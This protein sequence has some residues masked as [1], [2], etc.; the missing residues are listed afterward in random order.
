MIVY[1]VARANYI[2]DLSGAG[3]RR[4][5]GRWNEKGSA[6]LYAAQ[7]SSLAILEALAHSNS[8]LP[9]VNRKLAFVNV[10]EHAT[11]MVY[12]EIIMGPKAWTDYPAPGILQLVG[13]DWLNKGVDLMLKVPSVLN[14]HEFNILLNPAH[15]H[16]ADVA[17]L[18]THDLAI[19]QRLQTSN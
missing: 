19:D 9:P 6:V 3:A 4:Y 15:P 2:D 13:T 7:S 11:A 18:E 5:G 12:D 14:P 8:T 1:R 10:P 17:V 16:F